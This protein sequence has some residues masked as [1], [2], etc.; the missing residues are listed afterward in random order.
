MATPVEG[1]SPIFI[2][3]CTRSGTTLLRDLLRSHPRLT[4]PNESHFIPAFYRAYGDPQD[5][6]QA[7]QLAEKI[8]NF[9]W[10]RRW[11]MS[12][13][14][15]D[16]ADCRSFREVLC[17]LYAAWARQENKPRWGDKTPYYI[18]AIPL[19]VELFPAAKVI[20]VYRDGR[21]VALS[22]LRSRYDPCNLFMAATFWKQRVNR[23]REAGAALPRESYMEVRYEALLA[24]PA[25]TLQA[26]CS[27]LGE[28]FDEAL[29]RPTPLP[30]STAPVP[31]RVRPASSTEIVPANAGKWKTQMSAADR[32][33]FE[34]VA[35]DLLEALGYETEGRRRHISK[36]E[37]W[38]WRLHHHCGT[39]VRRL[40]V[41]SRRQ[42][43]GADL[44]VR[45]A[46]LHARVR[47]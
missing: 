23:G 47:G 19:L 34:S 36:A 8:L 9:W 46:E 32:I 4:F 13:Q 12:L 7:V 11:G 29:L 20:H 10:V 45:W 24:E 5:Q 26:V 44:R 16:F 30:G 22:W 28:A 42:Q 25:R 6:R 1:D 2:V 27:F 3:G 40:T 35:G 37:E 43:L 14:P 33:L 41:R 18:L 15:S 21:D 17:R 31:W 38:M 39:L